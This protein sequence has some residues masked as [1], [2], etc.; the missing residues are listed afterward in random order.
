MRKSTVVLC[1]VSVVAVAA[2]CWLWRQWQHERSL[3]SDL[4][5]R[6]GASLCP[7]TPV[8]GAGVEHEVAGPSILRAPQAAKSSQSDVSTAE[9]PRNFPGD[10]QQRLLKNPDYRK[11]MRVQQ[12][13]EIE[14]LYRD[15]PR[16][17]GL[18]TEQAGALFDL[19][20]EGGVKILEAQWQ[21]P[22]EGKSRQAAYEKVREQNDAEV[23]EMLGAS[24]TIR[25][26]EFRSTMQ[27]R[28]E[29]DS[30][31]NELARGAEPMR[32]DQVDPMIA[33]VNSEVQRMN[34]ELRDSGSIMTYG[35]DPANDARRTQIVI[36][37]NQR[38]LDATRSILS[39]TQQA[40]LEQL[41]RRQRL[42]MESE[43]ELA[44]LRHDAMQNNAPD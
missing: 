8:A 41:Y 18:T 31:R 20:A 3:N 35:A 33:I 14:Q 5:D 36:A 17:L 38:I 24:N 32:E 34:Q 15:L 23:A 28:S 9:F 19:M 1:G 30:V 11:A 13:Q 39:G 16:A 27:S 7:D 6:R 44:R 37:T 43:T 40:G 22:E 12:R 26:N 21:K 10:L 4:Q 29:V 2:S 42:Q 25:L